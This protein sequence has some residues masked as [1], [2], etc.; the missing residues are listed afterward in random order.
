MPLVLINDPLY[1]GYLCVVCVF[2]WTLKLVQMGC[3]A[4]WVPVL[5]ALLLGLLSGTGQIITDTY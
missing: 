2:L 1:L 5:S 4:K 3:W